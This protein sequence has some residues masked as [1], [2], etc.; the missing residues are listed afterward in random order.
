MGKW[1]TKF[2]E[3]REVF[4]HAPQMEK[5]KHFFVYSTLDMLEHRFIVHLNQTST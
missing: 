3:T 2:A 4:V 1:S 5:D